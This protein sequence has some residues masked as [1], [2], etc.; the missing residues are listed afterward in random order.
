M[1]QLFTVKALVQTDTDRRFKR[2]TLSGC[3]STPSAVCS[4]CPGWDRPVWWCH[5]WSPKPDSGAVS[6]PREL[7]LTRGQRWTSDCQWWQP[8]SRPSTISDCRSPRTT[9]RSSSPP[10]WGCCYWR[11]CFRKLTICHRLYAMKRKFEL[12]I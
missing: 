2:L 11:C 3:Q 4:P 12:V 8:V 6:G 9:G 10:P 7:G 1:R 5:S